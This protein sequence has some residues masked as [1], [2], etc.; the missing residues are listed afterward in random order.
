M[1]HTFGH[2]NKN[3]FKKTTITLAVVSLAGL[4]GACSATRSPYASRPPLTASRD[5]SAPVRDPDII[6]GGVRIPVETYYNWP[7][8]GDQSPR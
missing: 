2:M 3:L 6:T 5:S 8:F 1:G 7:P 4:L